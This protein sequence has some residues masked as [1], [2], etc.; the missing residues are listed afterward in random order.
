MLNEARIA[1]TKTLGRLKS[2]TTIYDC[3]DNWRHRIK[4]EKALVPDPCMRRPLCLDGQSACKA[5]DVGAVPDLC[6]LP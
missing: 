1:P 6:G 5:E 4:V 3:G 2:F